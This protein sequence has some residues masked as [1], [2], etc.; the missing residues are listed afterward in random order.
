MS[1]SKTSK[2]S[3]QNSKRSKQSSKTSKRSI[4]S[5]L[6]VE[7]LS[8]VNQIKIY[9][10]Q[11]SKY[12]THKAL[13]FL[14]EELNNK[15]DE[16]IETYI[17]KYDRFR[18]PDNTTIKLNNFNNNSQIIKELKI[19]NKKLQI[20]RDKY[21]AKSEDSDISNILDEIFGTLNKTVY[22]LT[23]N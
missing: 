23:L 19:C 9:H 1:N 6:V 20:L 10:W 22:L 17:G 2:R 12:S 11:T 7:L 14:F 21:L 3:K 5:I 4:G 13:D 8:I 18:L 15:I 16:L